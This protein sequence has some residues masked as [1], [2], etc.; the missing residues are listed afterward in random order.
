M[1][2]SDVA[3]SAFQEARSDLK[4]ER[5][6]PIEAA[7]LRVQ[8]MPLFVRLLK[9]CGVTDFTLLWTAI[10]LANCPVLSLWCKA[11]PKLLG[12]RSTLDA[13]SVR[14]IAHLPCYAHSDLSL[15]EN[16]MADIVSKLAPDYS[17]RVFSKPEALLAAMPPLRAGAGTP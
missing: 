11:W 15:T 14:D 12:E 16:R 4:S 2:R 7:L 3:I 10:E 13:N 6:D 1:P 9:V 8:R 17:G 5:A